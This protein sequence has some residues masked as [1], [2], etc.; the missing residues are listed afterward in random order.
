M[1]AL[2]IAAL[3]ALTNT[4]SDALKLADD[5]EEFGLDKSYF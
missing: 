4:I 5:L 2:S 3:T 1:E